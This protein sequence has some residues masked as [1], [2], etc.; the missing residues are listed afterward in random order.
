MD[1][2]AGL[3]PVINPNPNPF[4]EKAFSRS[5]PHHKLR[6]RKI[7]PSQMEITDELLKEYS[8]HENLL[9]MRASHTPPCFRIFDAYR[10]CLLDRIDAD[11]CK[12]I[13]KAYEPCAADMKRAALAHRMAGEEERRKILAAKAKVLEAEAVGGTAAAGGAGT[14]AAAAGSEKR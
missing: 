7:G 12:Q 13:G 11:S 9:T 3:K 4:T 5:I 10:L 14:G 2:L 6:G 1:P 8:G